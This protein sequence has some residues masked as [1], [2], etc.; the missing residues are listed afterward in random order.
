MS[1]DA[2][3]S[4]PP[5][6][7]TRTPCGREETEAGVSWCLDEGTPHCAACPFRDFPVLDGPIAWG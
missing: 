6:L 7:D 2:A 1:E 3:P 5:S 4:Q